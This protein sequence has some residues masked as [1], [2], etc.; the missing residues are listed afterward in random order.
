MHFTCRYHKFLPKA[1]SYSS[2][3][4]CGGKQMRREKSCCQG[5]FGNF[6]HH[7]QILTAVHALSKLPLRECADVY[8][9]KSITQRSTAHHMA[10]IRRCMDRSHIR[11]QPLGTGNKINIEQNQLEAE[12]KTSPKLEDALQVCVT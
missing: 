8:N 7:M 11:K 9:H 4:H 3:I 1:S 10:K 6:K 12:R 2:K 5:K